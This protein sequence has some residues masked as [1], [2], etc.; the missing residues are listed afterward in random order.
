VYLEQSSDNYG[1]GQMTW[2]HRLKTPLSGMYEV[3][4]GEKKFIFKVKCIHG[5]VLSYIISHVVIIDSENSNYSHGQA[6]PI[7]LAPTLKTLQGR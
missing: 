7:I 3:I 5:Q 6:L 2:D 1:A 4:S